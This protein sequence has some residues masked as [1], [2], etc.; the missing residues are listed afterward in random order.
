VLGA[1]AAE[2]LLWP[3]LEK[4]V[5]PDAV[6]RAGIRAICLERLR[7]EARG[8]V[9]AE[10][11]RHAAFLAAR[12]DGPIARDTAAA[13]AQHYEVP[14]ELYELTLGQ[15]LKYSGGLWP[16][17]VTTLDASEEAML[18]ET[19]RRARLEDGMRVL[20]LGCGWGALSLWIAEKFP[21]CSV[22]GVSNSASQRRHILARRDAR[23]LGD[24]RRSE[25]RRVVTDR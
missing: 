3:M 11:R 19:C 12:R 9:E 21:S 7:D 1:K 22:L 24:A 15:R 20:D 2:R 23:G 4:G 8:G 5:V 6:L 14:A 17:G 16:A 10:R 13:N 18:A 25:E